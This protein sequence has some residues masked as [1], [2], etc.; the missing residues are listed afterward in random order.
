VLDSAS[1]MILAGLAAFGLILKVGLPQAL[2]IFAVARGLGVRTA[3]TRYGV[4]VEILPNPHDLKAAAAHVA[5]AS[6]TVCG[7]SRNSPS[8]SRPRRGRRADRN[9][10]TE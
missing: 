3:P 8:Q 6:Q 2:A 9:L 10:S 7:P 1:L 5:R 4:A